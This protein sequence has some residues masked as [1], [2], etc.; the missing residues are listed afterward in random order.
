MNARPIKATFH[1]L[2]KN[3]RTSRPGHRCVA[4][5][6][7]LRLLARYLSTL[8]VFY[9][10]TS[11]SFWR[12]SIEDAPFLWQ[13]IF[14]VIRTNGFIFFFNSGFLPF[15]ITCCLRIIHPFPCIFRAMLSAFLELFSSLIYVGNHDDEVES[16]LRT[17]NSWKN[18][19]W[20]WI[21][22]DMGPG[23]TSRLKKW[24]EF[25]ASDLA[26]SCGNC[27]FVFYLGIWE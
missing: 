1:F 4:K 2:L 17:R 21:R 13:A 22:V 3:A 11:F 18:G 20:S 19:T 8:C 16:H 7:T 15:L 14:V 26:N 24:R 6:T 27:R 9:S 5:A 23:L 12:R 25:I 10:F